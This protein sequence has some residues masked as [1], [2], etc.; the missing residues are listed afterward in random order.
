MITER[1]S[2]PLAE[3]QLTGVGTAVGVGVGLG[4]WGTVGVGV[5]GGVGVTTGGVALPGTNDGK[6]G[7][8]IEKGGGSVNSA[9]DGRGVVDGRGA[10]V[11]V[12]WTKIGRLDVASTFPPA[13]GV[14]DASA[15]GDISSAIAPTAN[16][17]PARRTA[18]NASK[19]WPPPPCGSA[20]SARR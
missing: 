16:S 5:G 18:P 4:V 3:S 20:C 12:S 15:E 14:F 8:T 10:G 1:V 19:P 7:G 6:L 17:N 13:I 11:G 9:K 2:E